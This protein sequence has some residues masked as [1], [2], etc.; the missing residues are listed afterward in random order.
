MCYKFHW[1]IQPCDLT[2]HVQD[3]MGPTLVKVPGSSPAAASHFRI[4]SIFISVLNKMKMRG[5]RLL[6][7]QEP[8]SFHLLRIP[9]SVGILSVIVLSFLYSYYSYYYSYPQTFQ[10]LYKKVPQYMIKWKIPCE[11]AYQDLNSK[12]FSCP[13]VHICPR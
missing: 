3:T 12:F 5:I 10:T 13:K 4:F 1:S 8:P 2:L 9:I 11:R 7:P 6:C